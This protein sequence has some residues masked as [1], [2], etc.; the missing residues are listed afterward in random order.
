[1]L[2]GTFMGSGE[3]K[4]T[5][6]IDR[7]FIVSGEKKSL[8]MEELDRVIKYHYGNTIPIIKNKDK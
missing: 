8:I 4:G 1:V 7:A 6:I 3:L 2:G 5:G